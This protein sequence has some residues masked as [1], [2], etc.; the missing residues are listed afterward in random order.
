M[1]EV[2]GLILGAPIQ[3]ILKF[4]TGTLGMTRFLAMMAD[5]LLHIVALGLIAPLRGLIAPL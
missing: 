1:V 5:D 3:L 4:G 2:I